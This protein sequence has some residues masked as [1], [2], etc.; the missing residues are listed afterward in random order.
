MTKKV[1]KNKLKQSK[2]FD[3]VTVDVMS[4]FWSRK[5]L[6]SRTLLSRKFSLPCDKRLSCEQQTYFL[7]SLLSLRKITSPEDA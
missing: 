3:R 7:S 5:N 4:L 6:S 1:F 2:H